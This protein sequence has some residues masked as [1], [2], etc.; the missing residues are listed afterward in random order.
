[1][2]DDF[3][4]DLR[5]LID[6]RVEE[7]ETRVTAVE[8]EFLNDKS[9]SNRLSKDIELLRKDCESFWEET[10]LQFKE[11]NMQTAL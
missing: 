8:A 3:R 1:L 2:K 9:F 6:E 5:E 4:E 10:R 7:M 11:S